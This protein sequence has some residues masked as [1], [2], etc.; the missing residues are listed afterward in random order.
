MKYLRF[1]LL[2][3]ILLPT[4]CLFTVSYILIGFKTANA[5]VSYAERE[6]YSSVDQGRR[7]IANE[8]QSSIGVLQDLSNSLESIHGMKGR[9]RDILPQLFK[10]FLKRYDHLFSLWVYFEPNGWDNK[11]S[12]F[13]NTGEYDETGNYAVWAFREANGS[14]K[15]STEAWGVE[16]YDNEYY[17]NA[18]KG[19]GLYQSTPYEEEIRDGYSVQM[20]TFSRAVH[21]AGGNIIGVAGLDISLEFLNGIMDSL[22][23][24]NNS[25][26]TIATNDGLIVAD[27]FADSVGKYLSDTHATDTVSAASESVNE[28]KVSNIKTLSKQLNEEVMQMIDSLSVDPTLPDWTYLISIPMSKIMEEPMKIIR[29]MVILNIGTLVI[30][31]LLIIF[32]SK[33]ITNPLSSLKKSFDVIA[34]GDLRNT[35]RIKT[36]DEVGQLAEGFN[37]LTDSLNSNLSIVRSSLSHLNS[38]AEELSSEMSQTKRVFDSIAQSITKVITA[39]ADNNRG[40]DNANNSVVSIKGSVTNLEQ[41]IESQMFMLKESFSTIEDMISNIQ[42]IANVVSESSE[43]YTHLRDASQV[44]DEVLNNVISRIHSIYSQ[45]ES[46]LD[47]NTVIANIA[48]Q[49]NLLSMNAAIEAAHAGEAGKGFA[50]VADEIRKLA[51]VTS[52]QSTAIDKSLTSIVAIIKDIAESSTQVGENFGQIQ[53]L[54]DTVTKLEED[55][56]SSLLNQSSGSKQILGTLDEMKSVTSNV[57]DESVTIT[58]SV[59][60]LFREIET[61]GD[62]SVDIKDNISQV[63]L[64]NEEIKKVIDKAVKLTE[65]NSHRI[66]EVN[67]N[68]SIFKL[69]EEPDHQ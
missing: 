4:A 39:G 64:D 63:H 9:D 3:Y 29:Y 26:S 44:G 25:Y 30:L 45:S 59:E 28:E 38:N 67:T 48:S 36:R 21:D 19:S 7:L 17:A 41:N 62:N 69:R 15:V 34:D 33:L 35:V 5:L 12:E 40:I 57:H 46:L 66:E 1:K 60:S 55:V 43:Y 13:A 31:T 11:D 68:L 16:S 37:K 50:V 2:I 23:S 58:E 47:T 51:E 65:N 56:K 32:I 6:A 27:S 54:I 22:N 20:V 49:T 52:E 61:L 10:D 8:M 42:S 18:L 14:V 24:A 53:S